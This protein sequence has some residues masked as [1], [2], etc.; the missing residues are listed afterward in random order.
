[1]KQRILSRL[2]LLSRYDG[3]VPL[4]EMEELKTASGLDEAG[5]KKRAG[6][7]LNL[8][9]N[10]Y[11]W[12]SVGTIDK[13]FQSVIRAFTRELGIQPAYNLELDHNRILVLA[14]ERLF[15]EMNK[16]DALQEWLIRFAE[17]RLEESRSWNF[18]ND[19]VELGMQLFRE[20]FQGLFLQQD[21][22]SIEK[23]NLG[24][25]QKE[26][27]NQENQVNLQMA[28]VGKEGMRIMEQSGLTTEDFKG[29]SSSYPSL[30]LQAAAGE[31][32]KFSDAKLASLEI[33]D[34]WL[35]KGA[36][37]QLRQ[38]TDRVLIPLCKQLRDQQILLN[39]IV[40]IRQNIYTLGILGDIWEQIKQYTSERNLFLIADSGRFLRGVIGSNQVPFVYERTG[41][42]YN[43][44]M[45]DEFQDTSV[46][47]Y[48]NFK[49]LLDH[50]LSGGYY[51]LVVG[52]VK[53]SIYRWRNSD[54]NILSSEVESDFSHQQVKLHQLNRNYR[55]RELIVRFNNSI[56]QLAS[57]RLS[58]V[59]ENEL[60]GSATNRSEAEFQI[61]KFNHAYAD[62]VQEVPGDMENSG[63]AVHLEF[64]DHQ[65]ENEFREAVLERLPH[66]I[67]EIRSSGIEPGEIAILVRNRRE[68][69]LV[70]NSLLEFFRK[71]GEESNFRLVSSESLLLLNNR[72]VGLIRAALRYLIFP[73]DM[74]N[75][76]LLKYHYSLL[77][78]PGGEVQHIWFDSG[79]P[80]AEV[81]TSELELQLQQMKNLP[82]YELVE[83]MIHLFGL[84]RKEEDL[85]YLQALQDMVIDLQRREAL[86]I[87]EFLQYW[88]QQGFKKG[89][90]SSEDSNAIRI[91]TIHKSKG[92]EFKAV[93]IPYCHWEITTD[94]RK[95][96]ILW[97]RTR[98][99]A[100]DQIPVLPIRFSKK[101]QHTLFSSD[102]YEERMKGYMDNLN[103]L[104]V[105]FTRAQDVLYAGIPASEGEKMQHVG[106][107]IW[108]ILPLTPE[109]G[110]ALESLENYREGNAIS[111][112]RLP[113]YRVREE[114][115]DPWQ[116]TS[117][118]VMHRERQLRIRSR[119]DEYFLDEEG[120]F[121]SNRM[122]GNIMHMIFSRI[123]TGQDVD[124]V[125]S[126]F[127]R[128]GVLPGSE[129]EHITGQIR[130]M[131]SQPGVKSWF[132]DPSWTVYNERSILCGDGRVLRPD[133]IM[134]KG[135][136][137]IVVDFKFGGIEKEQYRR[138]VAAYMQ[139][140]KMLGYARVT[141]YIWYVNMGRTIQITGP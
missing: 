85:P 115:P 69:S 49:P 16:Q 83:S 120:R 126:S 34:K 55:S 38:L 97:C 33:L 26:L 127:Y 116:F 104:Y 81:L 125:V 4:K 11:S 9:L 36:G 137:V 24:K 18:R 23:E 42:R 112:G 109:K 76:A 29:K 25:F 124:R 88:E 99:T 7:L 41:N 95:S 15:Q 89:I 138:Q 47:Q 75:N 91:M 19:M 92:L 86:G 31:P 87:A 50:A 98:G 65:G 40:A 118:P 67:M 133:R 3:S 110:P 14:I 51:N 73:E 48:D 82:L 135:D 131:I 129:R 5:V 79:T 102:Y 90:H 141:G 121:Q 8:I 32:V 13:F 35:N 46:F 62:A 130:G 119:S 2:H 113:D 108:S 60:L 111:L 122:Y 74:R 84:D 78:S 12:F 117:Y 30:F 59:I 22:S 105:A 96:N 20:S 107:L 1:M 64:I 52:D 61:D 93:I 106:D 140:L 128:Q 27:D 100:F 80:P 56:F 39:T 54:W 66:W 77:C 134:T 63:G 37:E 58:T 132:S 21:L 101:M 44:L 71:T 10:D 68:G 70:A 43:H 123:Q 136:H 94:H 72:A 114:E 6:V 57:A 45:L 17:E 28:H 53:Q 103:L 139:Q